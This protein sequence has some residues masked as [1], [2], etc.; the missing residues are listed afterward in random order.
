MLI[1]QLSDPHFVPEDVRL[2][3]RLDT[4]GV[5]RAIERP[6]VARRRLTKPAPD[7]PASRGRWH[8]YK[9]YWAPRLSSANHAR[10]AARIGL[11]CLSVG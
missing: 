7:G 1:A 2:F 8:W 9:H 4:R 10:S 3:G 6:L 11:S 5:P